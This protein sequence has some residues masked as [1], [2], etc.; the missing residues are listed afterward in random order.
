MNYKSRIKAIMRNRK[1]GRKLEF[2][3]SRWNNKFSLSDG[4]PQTTNPSRLVTIIQVL[5]RKVAV[6]AQAAINIQ[7]ADTFFNEK[8]IAN[9]TQLKRNRKRFNMQCTMIFWLQI[10]CFDWLRQFTS[11]LACNTQSLFNL[12][13]Y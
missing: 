9:Y 12:K 2:L 5:N 13:S 10:Y 8:A 4:I 7:N 11:N 6:I 1:I 3:V